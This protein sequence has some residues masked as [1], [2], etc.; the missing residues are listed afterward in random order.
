MDKNNDLLRDGKSFKWHE[1]DDFL[2]CFI[3]FEKM[4]IFSGSSPLPSRC[5]RYFALCTF[6]GRW[7]AGG[8]LFEMVQLTIRG[9]QRERGAVGGG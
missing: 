3:F 6:G 7:V 5:V 2:T 8:G 9:F 4:Y 1:M